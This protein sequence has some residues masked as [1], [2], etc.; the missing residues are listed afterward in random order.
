M[1]Y[2]CTLY[3]CSQ[4]L[5]V[6]PLAFHTFSVPAISFLSVSCRTLFSKSRNATYK[7]LFYLPIFQMT[8]IGINGNT[9]NSVYNKKRIVTD[10]N[11]CEIISELEKTEWGE[12]LNSDDVNVSCE[13]FV[14][15]LTDIYRKKSVLLSQVR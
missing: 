15:K 6:D 1:S 11:I 9:N 2:S 4:L 7:G 3:M 5:F 8:D 14:N 10:R 13:T 12:I